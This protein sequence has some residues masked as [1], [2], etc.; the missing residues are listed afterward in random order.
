MY[1][2]ACE[3]GVPLSVLVYVRATLRLQRQRDGKVRGPQNS[4]GIPSGD[5]SLPQ[6]STA[7]LL[8]SFCC[9]LHL[10]RRTCELHC[11]TALTFFT[12]A[13]LC[14][15]A[16]QQHCAA[17]QALQAG[18]LARHLVRSDR[19]PQGCTSNEPRNVHQ[20]SI[21]QPLNTYR[22]SGSGCSLSRCVNSLTLV[23]MA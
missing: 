18:N 4:A 20:K 11:Y 22:S 9:K 14:R 5:S 1:N 10:E 3:T 2:E 12:A 16:C 6:S 21:H 8:Q 7:I 19:Q 17:V 23:T 13:V 15:C